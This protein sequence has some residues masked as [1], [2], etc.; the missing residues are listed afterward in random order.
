MKNILLKNRSNNKKCDKA[1]CRSCSGCKPE[2]DYEKRVE[3]KNPAQLY[4]KE[5][6]SYFFHYALRIN[7]CD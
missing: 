7:K 5:V 4:A 6:E 2:N 1:F 3:V